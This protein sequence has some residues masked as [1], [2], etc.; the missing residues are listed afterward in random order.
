MALGRPEVLTTSTQGVWLISLVMALGCPE[1]LTTST[2]GVWLK[3]LVMA[4]GRPDLLTTSTQG[5]HWPWPPAGD[6]DW[7]LVIQ[8]WTV[9]WDA[10]ASRGMCMFVS[11]FC[12]IRVSFRDS[13]FIRFVC[14]CVCVSW[15]WGQGLSRDEMWGWCWWWGWGGGGYNLF[16]R[17]WFGHFLNHFFLRLRSK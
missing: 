13:F 14:V 7:K 9:G 4:L 16:L 15:C 6:R 12:G 2:Q 5:G 10:A 3:L 1:V 8:T 11:G 17:W